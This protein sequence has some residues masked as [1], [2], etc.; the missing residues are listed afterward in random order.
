M[1]SLQ[2]AELRRPRNYALLQNIGMIY[3]ARRFDRKGDELAHAE[4]YFQRSVEL[5]PSDYFGHQQLAVASLR[6]ALATADP[7][8]REAGFKL[9]DERIGK[10]LELRPESRG[11]AFIRLYLR[12][13]KF[14]YGV[15]QQGTDDLGALETDIDALDPSRSQPSMKWMRI[16]CHWLALRASADEKAFPT[17]F[18]A[19]SLELSDFKKAIGTSGQ[20]VW[21]D[22][23]MLH[24]VEELSQLIAGLKFK[25]SRSI[26]FDWTAA[27]E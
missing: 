4:R 25:D 24:S 23:Q 27:L 20:D 19:L 14:A 5:K 17:K 6:R 21:R 2:E 11:A 3:L 9:A 8:A 18:H 1:R 26:R 13:A 7:T 22:A 16:A 15:K 10:A 12:L